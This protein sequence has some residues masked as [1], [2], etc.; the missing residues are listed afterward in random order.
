MRRI[1]VRLIR[2]DYQGQLMIPACNRCLATSNLRLMER[3]IQLVIAPVRQAGFNSVDEF[4][5][6]TRGAAGFGSTGK[7]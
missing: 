3:L 1:G 2:S 5:Q 4:V 7:L 6:S